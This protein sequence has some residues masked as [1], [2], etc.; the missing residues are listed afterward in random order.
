MYQGGNSMK[1][2]KLVEDLYHGFGNIKCELGITTADIE[3]KCCLS[4]VSGT[5]SNVPAF[6]GGCE[7]I[8]C[9]LTYNSLEQKV[10]ITI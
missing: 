1:L 3:M 4:G 10:E 6:L 7:V 2:Y 9:E 5:L 8:A